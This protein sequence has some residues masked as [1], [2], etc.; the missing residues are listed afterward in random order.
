MNNNLVYIGHILSKNNNK[1]DWDAYI[2]KKN[3]ILLLILN[4]KSKK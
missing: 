4:L 1:N 3:I 2:Y